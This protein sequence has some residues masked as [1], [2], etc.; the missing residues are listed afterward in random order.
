MNR[1]SR[2]LTSRNRHSTICYWVSFWA[3]CAYV[4]CESSLGVPRQ[5]EASCEDSVVEL[6]GVPLADDEPVGV[7]DEEVG[8]ARVRLQRSRQHHRPDLDVL[9]GKSVVIF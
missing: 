9:L 8:D 6:L 7:D 5:L 1:D 2:F 3:S 4:I